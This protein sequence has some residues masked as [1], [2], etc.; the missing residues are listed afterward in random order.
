MKYKVIEIIEVDREGNSKEKE[1]VFNT[2]NQTVYFIKSRM[3]EVIMKDTLKFFRYNKIKI[4]TEK[5]KKHCED[6]FKFWLEEADKDQFCYVA[7][8]LGWSCFWIIEEV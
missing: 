2:Y 4:T 6:D 3:R 5:L 1:S 7:S 8:Y